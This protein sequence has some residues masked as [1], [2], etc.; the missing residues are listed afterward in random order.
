MPTG[1]QPVSISK[2]LLYF[3][4]LMTVVFLVFA[5]LLF[6]TPLMSEMVEGNKRYLLGG[7]TLLYAAFRGIRIQKQFQN[8]KRNEQN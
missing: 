2:M 4:V 5:L 7:M 1:K 6:F 8:M 3:S